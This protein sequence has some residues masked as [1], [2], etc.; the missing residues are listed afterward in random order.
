MTK[1][2]WLLIGMWLS[3]P[4]AWANEEGPSFPKAKSNYDLPEQH[5]VFGEPTSSKR[6][7]IEMG[8]RQPNNPY[9]LPDPNRPPKESKPAYQRDLPEQEVRIHYDVK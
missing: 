6:L 4:L 7:S 9:G 8:E 2:P 1:T 5:N 3:S